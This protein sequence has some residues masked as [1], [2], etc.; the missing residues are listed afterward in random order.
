MSGFASIVLDA[1]STLVGIEGIAWLAGLRGAELAA[2][3]AAVTD[4]AM[5]GTVALESVYA[6]RLELI[7]PTREEV[8]ALSRAYRDAMAPGARAV[9]A[10]MLRAGREV[11]VVSGG[12]REA[13]LPLA[14]DLGL[15]A[16][17]VT[18]VDVVFD[19]RGAYA[20]AVPSPLMTD[21]GKAEVV[22]ALALP[23]PIL[24]VGDG[25]TDLA[26]RPEVDAFAAFVGFVRRDP[27][28]AGADFVVAS[29]GEVAALVA[30]GI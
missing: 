6:R 10:D 5:A 22:R 25:A 3:V 26:M 18:A 27:V 23:R 1:D 4:E 24:A 11:R 8:A 30:G 14:R 28:V 29:F 19:A 2:R 9:V 16:G 12:L 7:G 13:L 21:G 15:A 17:A 20:G